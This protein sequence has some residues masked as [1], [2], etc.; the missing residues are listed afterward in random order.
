VHRGHPLEYTPD[1][2]APPVLGSR[3]ARRR[4]C[5]RDRGRHLCVAC[6]RKRRAGAW[7]PGE[8]VD[9]VAHAARRYGAVDR[10]LGAWCAA[11]RLLR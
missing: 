8:A 2:R 10:S 3:R 5:A 4:A 9:E 6:A 1:R 7:R 11:V